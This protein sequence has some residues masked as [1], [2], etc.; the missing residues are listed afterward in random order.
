MARRDSR[1]AT[2]VGAIGRPGVFVSV[3]VRREPDQYG[4]LGT[5]SPN[6]RYLFGTEAEAVTY[7][8]P[9]AK[10]GTDPSQ[11]P[12]PFRAIRPGSSGQS[13]NDPQLQHYR[14]HGSPRY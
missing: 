11:R 13:T 3:P 8:I 12:A 7:R 1:A 2:S 9:G 6:E 10:Y 4:A 14:G 5:W